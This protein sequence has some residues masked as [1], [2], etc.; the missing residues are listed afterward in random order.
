MSDSNGTN[1]AP[2]S[3]DRKKKRVFARKPKVAPTYCS[4]CSHKR[5]T[6]AVRNGG[7]EVP[8][9]C[10]ACLRRI[11]RTY[12]CVKC[13]KYRATSKRYPKP[14]DEICGTCRGRVVKKEVAAILLQV[15][16]LAM[17][18]DAGAT[19]IQSEYKDSLRWLFSPEFASKYIDARVK[20][21]ALVNR[22]QALKPR[23]QWVP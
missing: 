17:I 21:L 13:H 11:H 16:I 18:L 2:E 12:Q 15:P 23:T 14:A 1:V 8:G 6:R 20:L 3:E 9:P 10:R 22:L 5:S 7:E 19:K 4:A